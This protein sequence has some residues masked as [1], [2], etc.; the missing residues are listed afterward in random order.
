MAEIAVST[1]PVGFN[2]FVV[3]AALEGR[4]ELTDIFIRLGF[5]TSKLTNKRKDII[6]GH[7]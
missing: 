5:G 7:L 2:V 4:V 1:P 6:I 3:Q